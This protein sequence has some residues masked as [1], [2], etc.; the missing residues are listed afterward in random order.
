MRWLLQHPGV[1]CPILGA[2][3]TAHL[4]DS[5]Q[6]VEFELNADQMARLNP[7]SEK[8]QPYPYYFIHTRKG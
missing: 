5:L 1:T 4:A 7:V 8:K 3:T 6:S 2:R